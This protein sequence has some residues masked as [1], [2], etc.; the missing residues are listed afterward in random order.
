MTKRIKHL[1]G[2]FIIVGFRKADKTDASKV[3]GQN[4]K[5]SSGDSF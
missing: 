3:T 2:G 4:Q 1:W 5:I